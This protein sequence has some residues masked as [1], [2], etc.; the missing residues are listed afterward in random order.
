[1]VNKRQN[2]AIFNRQTTMPKYVL[3]ALLL[4]CMGTTSF[5]NAEPKAL[6]RNQETQI[7][8][9]AI[10]SRED[11][12]LSNKENPPPNSLETYHLI[13]EIVKSSLPAEN[14]SIEILKSKI[15][16]QA[17]KINSLEK[18]IKE[19]EKPSESSTSTI[20]LACVS[21]IIT[22]LGVLIAIVTIF[23]YANIKKEAIGSAQNAA[24]SIIQA[25][26]HIWLQE[27][28]EKNIIALIEEGRFD[29]IIQNA[30]ANIEYRGISIPDG[31][32]DEGGMQ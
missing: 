23:G 15:E 18:E 3:A 13:Q 27:A 21:V 22:V 31:I 19:F 6:E 16:A 28:T 25:S 26:A 4:T 1:M 12:D 20:V 30:V 24:Q 10:S 11:K 2:P 7:S 9:T 32:D 17:E 8:Q 5:S 29:A 14:P